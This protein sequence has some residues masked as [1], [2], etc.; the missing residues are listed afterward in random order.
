M[1][2]I[3]VNYSFEDVKR[4]LDGIIDYDGAIVND[5]F[6]VLVNG[7]QVGFSSYKIVKLDLN[8][9]DDRGFDICSIPI[10]YI[11]SLLFI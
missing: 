10:K 4:I 5:K 1:N 11:S 3:N 8:F 9:Y 2:E 7:V 6:F